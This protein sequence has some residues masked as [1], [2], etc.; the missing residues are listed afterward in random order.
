ME[1]LI[2]TAH[3]QC[4]IVGDP[5][6]PFDGLL[7]ALVMRDAYGP[8]VATHPGELARPML[9]LPLERAEADKPTWFYAASWARWPALRT[10]GTDHW[11]KRLDLALIDYLRPQT[12]RI[13]VAGGRYRSYHMPVFYRHALAVS[14]CVVGDGDEIARLLPHLPGLGK[15]TSQGWGA[16]LRWEIEP[17]SLDESVWMKGGLPARAIPTDDGSGR[18]YGYRPPYWLPANQAP[19]LLPPNK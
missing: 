5:S 13:D 7:S 4:G 14:W 17:A 6:L 2:I 10:E 15:K 12:A 19:C 16:V 11:S 1:P 8:Q 18:L 9:D 3:L